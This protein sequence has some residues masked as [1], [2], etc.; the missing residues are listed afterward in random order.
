MAGGEMQRDESTEGDA[1]DDGPID[2]TLIEN[3]S[4]LIG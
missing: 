3:S 2:A 1:A 4:H